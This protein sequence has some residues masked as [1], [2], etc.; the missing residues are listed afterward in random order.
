MNRNRVIIGMWVLLTAVVVYLTTPVSAG[1]A[2]AGGTTVVDDAVTMPKMIPSSMVQPVYPEP[3][4]KAGVMGTVLLGV[5]VA[6]DG[7]VASIKP[8]QEV[9]NH[10]AFTASA[11]AAV[12]KW[13]F[14]PAQKDGQA[15]AGSVHIPVRFALDCKKDKDKKAH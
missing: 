1:T 13:R 10:P 7:T 8:E 2:P 11:M 6:A 12:G 3:E 14:E 15:I 9:P 5:E 4:R